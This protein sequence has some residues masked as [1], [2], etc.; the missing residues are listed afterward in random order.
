M[1]VGSKFN[2]TADVDVVAILLTLLNAD[3]FVI[4]Q[5]LVSACFTKRIKWYFIYAIALL[6]LFSSR[7]TVCA[8][9]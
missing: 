3:Y 2:N 8:P 6:S 4:K 5:R 7:N 9:Y 1:V